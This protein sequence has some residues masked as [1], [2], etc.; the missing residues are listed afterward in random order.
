MSLRGMWKNLPYKGCIY[1]SVCLNA[2]SVVIIFI[3]RGAL[4]PIVPLFYGLPGGTEQLTPT[5][6]LLLAPATGLII[7]GINVFISTFNKDVFLKKSLV[8]SSAFISL[9]LTITVVKIILL[10]GF[11]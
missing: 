3:L 5:L 8:I 10:V 7:T 4:P 1:L 2:V 9:L 6:G 11:F